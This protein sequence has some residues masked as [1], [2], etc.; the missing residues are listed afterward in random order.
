MIGSPSISQEGPGNGIREFIRVLNRRKI[1]ILAPTVLVAG[2]AWTIASVTVPR[3][4][5]TAALTLDVHKVQIVDREV[6]SRL[7]LESSTLR[8]EL[9]VIR[10]RS[11]N[12]EVIVT[13]G[14]ASDLAV[15]REVHAWLSPWPYAARGMRDAVGRWFPGIVGKDPASTSDAVPMV[16]QSQLTDWLVGNLNVGNDG[17]SLTIVVSFTSES[18]ERAAQIANAIAQTYLDDQVLAK[19][20]ATMKA[21]TWLG[22]E[23]TKIRQQLEISEAAVDDFRRKSGLLPVR[24]GT[25]PGERLGDL[26]AQ[27]SNAHAERMRAELR[28]AA[29]ESD[30]ET[31]P[32]I[33]ASPTIQ[34]L[35]K[36]LGEINLS[37]FEIRAHS[38]SYKLTDLEAR[39][40]MLQT[41]IK[42]ET[43]RIIATLSSEVQLARKKEAELA[44]SFQEMETQLGD[45]AHSGVRLIQLER[46]AAA[47]RSIYETFLA[48]YKQA[49]EQESLSAPDARLISRAEPPEAP[50]YPNMLRF[51]LLGTVGGLAIGGAL[52]FAR[53]SLDQ[54]IRQASGVE[55]AT[56]IPVFGLLPKVSRWRGLQPQDYPVEDPHS[57]F[58]TALTRV[59][60]ALR[61][62]QSPGRKQMILVTSA[63]P[64]D[65]KTSFC[66][67]LARS[68][69]KSR[70][71]VLVIDADPY[72]SQ[73][74]T[75]FGASSCPAFGPI[76]EQ[77]VRLGDLVQKDAKS[78][79]HFIAAPNPDDL[80]LLLHS[81]GFT[82]LL[83]EA[84]QAYDVVII[85]TPPVMT[86]ADAA[87]IGRFVDIRLLVVRWGRTSWDQL[88]AAVGFLRLCRVGLDG[89]VM[90]GV[91]PGSASYSQLA[92][93]D[94]AP[95]DNQFMRPPS[96]RRLTEAE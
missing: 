22:E 66:T 73:I 40:A 6:V 20:R 27:L 70:M 58:G 72:R 38:P 48:R 69:A 80:Q 82:T 92:S 61:A 26:N 21:S 75:A 43:K 83:E 67:S 1:I 81:G 33:V 28:L 23:V 34:R 60:T 79:A 87:L 3:F 47:N 18:P 94:T 54:R 11:L 74:A 30:L 24:G 71:R 85:D 55:S 88:T 10:S 68:L 5:A 36:D 4:A 42:E 65:G 44:Q 86:R 63:Q 91:D 14:L 2:L 9:D 13:L 90:V 17:R 29:Q 95:S 96:D 41:A 32:D 35:R 15:A 39:A 46:E 78:A 62:P 77:R 31:L 49:A 45:A 76:V 7:P 57:R 89:I 51:L 16:T 93:F 12:E 64:G 8:S 50:I 52:A 56:G 53:E 84:R 37:I 59:H 25:I 19:N